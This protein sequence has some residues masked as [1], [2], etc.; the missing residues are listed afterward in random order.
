[1]SDCPIFRISITN[2]ISFSLKKNCF[3]FQTINRTILNGNGVKGEVTMH[4]RSPFEPTWLNFTVHSAK[5]ELRENTQYLRELAGYQIRNLPPDPTLA[6]KMSFC[7][8][9]GAV[10]NPTD[11]EEHEIPPAGFGTQDQYPVGDLSGKLEMRNKD[12]PHNYILPLTPGNEL[13]GIY[14]DVFLPMHGVHSV[15]HRGFSIERF[16]RTDAANTTKSI[17][18]CSTLTLY[19]ENRQYQMPMITAQV[20]FRYP[21]VGKILFRQP[22]DDPFHETTVIVEYVIFNG[23]YTICV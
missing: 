6:N 21:I 9:T 1:M 11:V 12:Y 14:W 16:N 18:L 20:L 8:S 7:Q 5:N 3:F 19:Q 2:I 22:R 10:Y 13:D 17:W 15:V 4:Q 23:I